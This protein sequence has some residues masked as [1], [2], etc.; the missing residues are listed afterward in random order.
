MPLIDPREPLF[1]RII[2]LDPTISHYYTHLFSYC[3]LMFNKDIV[4][5]MDLKIKQIEDKL[6]MSMQE[7]INIME[8]NEDQLSYFKKFVR[9]ET[10]SGNTCLEVKKITKYSIMRELN[11]IRIWIFDMLK[12]TQQEIRF[13]R[14]TI[15]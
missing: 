15:T 14:V 6:G 9:I 5:K 12:E 2:G 3:R 11:L 13:Q 8:S 1:D 4:H 7:A 10:H